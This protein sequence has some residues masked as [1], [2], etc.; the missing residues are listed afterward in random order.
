MTPL[1]YFTEVAKVLNFSYAP[2]LISPHMYEFI[3][4]SLFIGEIYYNDNII[5]NVYF[6]MTHKFIIREKFYTILF[7]VKLEILNE[8]F[9]LGEESSW[10]IFNLVREYSYKMK[11]EENVEDYDISKFA[12]LMSGKFKEMHK[13]FIKNIDRPNEY[14][15]LLSNVEKNRMNRINKDGDSVVGEDSSTQL[16]V[17]LN[18]ALEKE[19]Q[20]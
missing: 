3:K 6:L 16:T 8:E 4:Q 7:N 17:A 9:L 14:K 13:P 5:K 18:L 1:S 19:I 20:P 2:S 15:Y 12:K 11:D 10:E